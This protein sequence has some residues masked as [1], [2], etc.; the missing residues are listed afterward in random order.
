[1][2][3]KKTLESNGFTIKFFKK[4][5][6]EP[7]PILL[8]LFQKIKEEKIFP[9]HFMKLAQTQYINQKSTLQENKT[10]RSIYCVNVYAEIPNKIL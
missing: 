4:F 2:A 10:Y 6:Q 9:T 3:K 1:M 5:E 7:S 8:K